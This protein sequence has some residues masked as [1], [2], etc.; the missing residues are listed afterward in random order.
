MNFQDIAKVAEHAA[1][2]GGRVLEEWSKKFTVSEKRRAD[3]VT[4]ADFSSQTAIHTLL[5]E[6]FPTHGFLG[7]EGL[8]AEGEDTDYRWI[9]DPL[10]GTGNY[11]HR[12]P[13][14]GVSIALEYQSELVVGV[15]YDPNRDE[16]FSAT[17]GGGTTLNGQTISVSENDTLDQSMVMA[18]LPVTPDP[19]NPA[20]ARFLNVLPRAQSVQ[21]TGSAALN[22]S[23]VAAGRLDGF[24]STSLKPWD[25]AAGV[26]LV[27]EAGGK[28][29]KIDNSEFAVDAP[30]LLATNGLQL[31]QEI[32]QYLK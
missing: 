15:V 28:V 18:S 16:L 6:K 12:F 21:R 25:M 14:Y 7:E 5:R 30:D 17:K 2:E 20:V 8:S 24:W 19:S 26:L 9:I 4:E 27:R 29:S 3:L 10:D 1:R 32:Q 31:H 11:V 23:N 13:Y 22:L